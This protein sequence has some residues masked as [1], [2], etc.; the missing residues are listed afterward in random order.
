MGTDTSQGVEYYQ[1]MIR[2][3]AALARPGYDFNL[4]LKDYAIGQKFL[5]MPAPEQSQVVVAAVH[6]L[7]QGGFQKALR[8][9]A[10]LMARGDIS[11]WVFEQT[12]CSLLKRKLPFTA[13]EMLLLTGW[14]CQQDCYSGRGAVIRQLEYHQ[15]EHG[16][17]AP[18]KVQTEKLLAVIEGGY[19]YAEYRNWAKRLKALLGTSQLV[20]PL[21][22][23][24][25]WADQATNEIEAL[26]QDTQAAWFNL[27]AHCLQPAGSAP[28]A[29]WLKTGVAL[30]EA[31]GLEDFKSALLRWFPLVDK[32]RTH[33]IE[34]W[35]EWQPN[36]N[37]ML[38]EVNADI[39]KGLVWLAAQR[40]D[41]ELARTLTALA[42]SAYRKISSVGPRCVR[43][44]NA[45][46]WALGNMPGTAGVAQLALLKLKVKFGTAQKG[47]EK[48]LLAAA[49][50][51]GLSP[52]EI[53]E[54]AVPT[55]GLQTVGCRQEQ[56][57]EYTAE[58]VVIGTHQTELRWRKGEGKTQ[59][60]IPKAVK[61][62]HRAEL[63]E[64]QGAA[65]DIQQMLV[66][67]RE[68]IENFY[69]E[70]RRWP[71]AVWR[72]RYLDHP[73]LGT[74]TRRLIW[75]FS[76]AGQTTA[77]A[78]SDGKLVDVMGAA[79]TGLDEHTQV[80]LWHPLDETT[81]TVLAW[82]DWLAAR[83]I[84]Q[85]FKQAHR[86]IYVL[87]DAERNT[88]VYSNRFAAHII[89]QHQFNAL[90]SA[91]A[92]KNKLRLMV[93]DSCPPPQRL[94]PLWNMRAEFWV[95]SIGDNYGTD[96]NDSGTFLYMTTDQVR[97]YQLEARQNLAHASGGGYS[98]GY[99][100]DT[101]V[102]PGLLLETIPQLVF[103]EIMRD[104]DL[105]V[106]VASVANDPNWADGSHEN[107]N[108]GYWHNYSF[109][110]LSA[111]AQTRKQV[112][113][114]LIPRLKIAARC[115]FSDKFLVVR[116]DIR[117][118]KIHLGSGNILMEPNDQ[119]LCI[120]PARGASEGFDGKVFLPF[121]GDNMLA[122]I[123]SKAFLLADDK[124]IKDPTITRQIR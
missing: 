40:E 52:E 79:L 37:L 81:E 36:P 25:A 21:I 104:V 91:R 5:A 118:Y 90:C 112:L 115:S 1:Q 111:T 113:E 51:T 64:L 4:A 41:K 84:R 13:A 82:R 10:S 114:K 46:V 65:K 47:I 92:W 19:S 44:G 60:S 11:P 89:K 101:T 55:Y 8:E 28:S 2:E 50:R 109:G 77:R 14:A 96:T 99:W 108:V 105:F 24:E 124:S 70:Q 45:C 62:S 29:K 6:W 26:A 88:G 120:V 103:S 22:A 17:E 9:W 59:T 30:V 74:L 78:W 42:V 53:A 87:T 3:L 54:M 123:L 32:P 73:L 110:D 72:A 61:A 93:D 48:A 85:P 119:Y 20:N 23:G 106:G 76:T 12:A 107:R 102:Q 31:I 100:G 97:F 63:K 71:L 49:K 69:L 95:E 58:L 56:F 43:V 7:T 83:E 38:I 75:R 86:E 94:L 33:V 34:A 27:L 116:G 35:S 39:L 117:S 68:L 18:L 122:I 98:G 66:A 121:E 80:E 57:G 67:Q 16:L 15:A